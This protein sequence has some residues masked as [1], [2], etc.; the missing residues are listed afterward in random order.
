MFHHHQPITQ[1][2][3]HRGSYHPAGMAEYLV[4][5]CPVVFCMRPK[6]PVRNQKQAIGN[7]KNHPRV[8][9]K[10]QIYKSEEGQK[11]E[12]KTIPACSKNHG[13]DLN[14]KQIADIQIGRE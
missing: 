8:G 1:K 7:G 10:E 6:L 12:E 5:C 11:S 4:Q 13:I 9:K 14:P 3:I 2:I